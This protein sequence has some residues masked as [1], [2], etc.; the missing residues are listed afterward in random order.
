MAESIG[1][2][3]MPTDLEADVAYSVLLLASDE[4]RLVNAAD[5]VVDGALL[6]T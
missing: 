1:R 5:I 3:A 6:S 4:S 2:V